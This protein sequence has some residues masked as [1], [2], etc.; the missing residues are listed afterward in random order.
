ML[1]DVSNTVIVD[2]MESNLHTLVCKEIV[3]R[4]VK[5]DY[6][7]DQLIVTTH[8]TRLMDDARPDEIWMVDKS[9]NDDERASTLH[10]LEE[11]NHVEKKTLN[12]DYLI[13]IYGGIPWIKED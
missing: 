2:E 5:G 7:C 10:S 9:P 1:D 11:Y 6:S 13:G 4:M 3:N 8:E 12:S